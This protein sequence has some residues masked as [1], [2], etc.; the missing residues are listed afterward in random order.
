MTNETTGLIGIAG[1]ESR[2]RLY[3]FF[4]SKMPRPAL[5]PT[6]PPIQRVPGVRWPGH[7]LDLS[8]PKAPSLRMSGAMHLLPPHAFRDWTGTTLSL[9]AHRLFE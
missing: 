6:R 3:T 8:Y 2:R 5:A 9:P 4:F 1:F 7:D